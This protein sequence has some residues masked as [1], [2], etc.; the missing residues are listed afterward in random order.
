MLELL[1][2]HHMESTHIEQ[3]GRAVLHVALCCIIDSSSSLLS[4]VLCPLSLPI[5][6]RPACYTTVCAGTRLA[7]AHSSGWQMPGVSADALHQL[8]TDVRA[9]LGRQHFITLP[10]SSPHWMHHPAWQTP[11]PTPLH[12]THSLLPHLFIHTH[13]H[14]HASISQALLHQTA[15][16]LATNG[17]HANA[18]RRIHSGNLK[19][20][21]LEREK[22]NVCVCVLK[23][24]AK[25]KSIS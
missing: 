10:C 2:L 19:Y 11:C 24:L 6:P 16:T 7:D 25:K 9:P 17:S 4:M 1:K 14:T 12:Q 13:T 23:C 18:P 3:G 20:Q 21:S 22:E 15:I 8:M 5:S